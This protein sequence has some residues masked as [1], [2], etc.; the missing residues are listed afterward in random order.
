MTKNNIIKAAVIGDPIAH[1]MSPKIHNFLLQKQQI[2]GNYEAILVKKDDLESKIKN[3][4]EQGYAGLN[5]T[6]PHKEQIFELCDHKSQSAILT[7]AVNT[8]VFTKNGKI[9]GHNSDIDGFLNNLHHFQPNF[10]LKNKTAY[11]IGAGGAARAIIY[12]LIKSNVSN[13]IIT[14]RNQNRAL[15]LI[16]DF[17]NFSSQKNCKINFL[18]KEDFSANLNNCDILINSTSLGMEGQ[19]NL[20][21]DI[22]NLKNSAI[23]YDIVYKPLITP[24]LKSAQNQNNKIVTGI[25]MLIY[26]ALVGF[27]LF[28]GQKAEQKFVTELLD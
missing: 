8:V 27:E 16:E 19:E 21:I 4:Q 20:E 15:K 2:N 5:V 28:F 7:G 23:V 6:I 26:Q 14:N 25:G 11:V 13:I 18:N 22:T 17:R 1:S 3:L 24:L 10:S 12:G 9:F